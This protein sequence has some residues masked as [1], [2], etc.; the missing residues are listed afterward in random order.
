MTQSHRWFLRAGHVPTFFESFRSVQAQGPSAWSFCS[1]TLFSIVPFSFRSVLSLRMSMPFRSVLGVLSQRTVPF[2]RFSLSQEQVHPP[3]C[4]WSRKIGSMGSWLRTRSWFKRR[5][6]L[7]S[8]QRILKLFHIFDTFSA[9]FSVVKRG[10]PFY[11]ENQPF[12]LQTSLDGII[13]LPEN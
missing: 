10:K 7:G 11:L 12:Y 4:S 6:A 13:I 3:F 9:T 2:P 1:G 8:L 5:P